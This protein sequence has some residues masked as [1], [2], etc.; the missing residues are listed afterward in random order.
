MT[1]DGLSFDSIPELAYFIFLKEHE[2]SFEFHP[3]MNFSYEYNGELRN[4]FPD[5]IVEGKVKE[6]K[7]LQFFENKDPNGKM[8]NPY[9]R[10]LDDLYEAKH[11]C[12]LKNNVE[13]ITDYEVYVKYVE[14]KYDKN[15]IEQFKC[16]NIRK[17]VDDIGNF[18]FIKYNEENLLNDWNMKKDG[19]KIIQ[20][21]MKVFGK[22]VLE[23]EKVHIWL[24]QIRY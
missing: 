1:Y 14:E 16:N 10:T 18:P 3:K 11:Q 2:I 22:Q 19:Y 13:I 4:Y 7:G 5:F 15:Y 20:H 12:M 24:G 23:K 17:I 6:I 9:D 8:I 21:F